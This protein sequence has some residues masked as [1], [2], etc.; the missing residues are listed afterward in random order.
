ME[1]NDK[2]LFEVI[3]KDG[4]TF[5][6][7]LDGHTEGFP[8]G[9]ILINRAL[10]LVCKLQALPPVKGKT[11]LSVAVANADEGVVI[12]FTDGSV[13]NIG[14]SCCYGS[15]EYTEAKDAYMAKEGK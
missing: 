1:H 2:P 11:V 14:Y 12:T 10:P 8:E 5:K 9:H 13:L 4:H 15:T 3:A 6:L 7:W